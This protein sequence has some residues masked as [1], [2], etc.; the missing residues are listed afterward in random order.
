MIIVIADDLTGAAEIAG[1]GHS[2]GLNT[3]LLTE[4]TDNLP[5]CDLM[6]IATDTRSM[7]EA[8]AVDETHRLCQAIKQALPKLS[9]ARKAAMTP[10]QRAQALARPEEL[11]HIFKKTDS[12][13]RGHVHL[14]L[15][16]L[17]EESRYEQVMYMPANPSKGRTIR[18]GRYFIDGTPLDQ[19]EFK[20]DPEF[21]ATTA[22]VAAAIGVAPGS[23]LRICDAE[24][25]QDVNRAVKLAL[26]NRTATLLAGAADL[27]IA[28]LEE[29]GR[30]PA[31]AKAFPGLSEKGSALIICGSTQSTDVSAKP[32]VRRHNMSTIPMPQETFQAVTQQSISCK[33]ATDRWMGR[34]KQSQIVLG[35]TASFVLTLPYPSAG[36]REAAIAL[37]EVTGDMA[38]RLVANGPLSEL[39]I[40]GGATAYSA[41]KKLGWSRFTVVNHIGPGIVRLHCLDA[42][43]TH[44]TIKPGS[45]DWL[46][47]FD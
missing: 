43:Q 13:L 4:V 42:Q 45:Y 19:T 33:E 36:T 41:I 8:Q 30:K 6:V 28:F 9:E 11:L 7:T 3:A 14:E 34:L 26:N 29:L 31:R 32:Y 23:R 21:P 1:I 16:A 39:V 2:Y 40:E 37:R 18:G 46:N 47:L 10:L 38:Q 35:K 27:F 25:K 15:R 5:V 20:L 17:V 44:L 24:D 22:N 12:A